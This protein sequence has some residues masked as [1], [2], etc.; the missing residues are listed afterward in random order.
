MISH[1]GFLMISITKVFVSI[2]SS[3]TPLS[4]L[5]VVPLLLRCISFFGNDFPSRF[6]AINSLKW[7]SKGR[8]E[9]GG[10]SFI[11]VE[12]LD[13]LIFSCQAAKKVTP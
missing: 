12:I 4:G 13:P 10:N 5:S 1:T 7:S 2:A 6:V 9:R 8:N 3:L 11:I